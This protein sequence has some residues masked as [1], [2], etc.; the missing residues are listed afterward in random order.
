M[1]NNEAL[2]SQLLAMVNGVTETV[3]P[4]LELLRN[5]EDENADGESVYDL[6]DTY[7]HR[8]NVTHSF[9][10]AGGGPNMELVVTMSAH[11]S[12][13]ISEVEL[14]ATWYGVDPVSENYRPG[15]PVWDYA[16]YLTEGVSL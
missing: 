9:V 2:H 1:T 8:K 5:G 3:A 4:A 12:T 13:E 15:S 14:L 6:L 11:D 16:E 7:G 10:L